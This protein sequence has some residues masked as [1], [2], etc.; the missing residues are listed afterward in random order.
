MPRATA[1]V[2][3]RSSPICARLANTASS[4]VRCP[5]GNAPYSKSSSAGSM[6]FTTVSCSLSSTNRCALVPAHLNGPLCHLSS[7]IEYA[8]DAAH[9]RGSTPVPSVGSEHFAISAAAVSA[10]SFTGDPTC[11]RCQ[12]NTS[13][14]CRLA[15]CS[16]VSSISPANWDTFR[17]ACSRP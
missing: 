8:S 2:Y 10:H 13:T 12:M 17:R 4:T 1:P 3:L 14:S 15:S 5:S 16:N 11:A 6:V 9:T 7:V